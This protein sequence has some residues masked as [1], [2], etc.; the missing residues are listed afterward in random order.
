MP[1]TVHGK[2]EIKTPLTK[3]GKSNLLAYFMSFSSLKVAQTK[4][5]SVL[6]F[7]IHSLFRIIKSGNFKHFCLQKEDGVN[8]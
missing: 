5:L 7:T 3:P 1:I 4:V 8:N 2:S 6:N